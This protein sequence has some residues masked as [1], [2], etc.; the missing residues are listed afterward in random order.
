MAAEIAFFGMF[1]E[2]LLLFFLPVPYET[3][4]FQ[5]F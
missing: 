3:K 1:S 5:L 2:Y 4:E